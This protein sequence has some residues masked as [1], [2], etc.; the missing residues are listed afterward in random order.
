M[1]RVIKYICILFFALLISSSVA[2]LKIWAGDINGDEA[3]VIAAASGTF[4][5]NG[6]TYKAYSSY[7]SQLYSYLASDDVDLTAAQADKAIS[8]I[9]SNVQSGAASGY[10][11]EVTSSKEDTSSVGTT[12]ITDDSSVDNSDASENTVDLDDWTP[13]DET[14]DSPDNSGDS[15]DFTDKASNAAKELSDKEVKEMFE[16]IESEDNTRRSTSTKPR[17]TETDA[18]IILSEDELVITNGDSKVVLEADSSIVP[19]WCCIVPIVVSVITVIVNTLV[20][21]VLI[22]KKCIRLSSKERKKPLDG[23]KTR[24]KIRKMSRKVLVV[25]SAVS[26]VMTFVG[27]ALAIGLYNN[28]RII[29]NIQSSGYFKYAYTQYLTEEINAGGAEIKEYEDFLISEKQV[30]QSMQASDL[31][32]NCSIAPYINRTQQDL[33]M[34]LV[35]SVGLSVISL[36]I[37]VILNVTMDLRRDRGVKTVAVSVI[38][39]TLATVII[40]ITLFVIHSRL[41]IFI[42]PDYLYYFLNEH[43]DWII[44]LLMIVGTFGAVIG[45]TLTGVYKNMQRVKE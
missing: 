27:L 26:A 10:I 7:I 22:L 15:T 41:K 14:Q 24:R 5:Y 1:N 34:T 45:M 9:Y 33:R 4:T 30:L 8:Y 21:I 17:A 32:K 12:D 3:R 42:E 20:M 38:A 35:I 39:G 25:S 36:I 31:T 40:A 6:K 19:G 16:D 23:H 44:K 18:K 2:S 11:Y 43:V 37:A 29:Q 13:D 28:S